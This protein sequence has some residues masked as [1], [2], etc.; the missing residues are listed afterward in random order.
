MQNNVGIFGTLLESGKHT[1]VTFLVDGQ[2]VKAHKAI[3]V[4]HSTVFAA[5]FEHECVE[6]RD[7]K[8]KITDISLEALKQLLRYMYTG[9]VCWTEDREYELFQAADKVR[10]RVAGKS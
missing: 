2:E 6:K 3:L 1:D 8:V 5:M 9:K 7:G 4:A 10:G